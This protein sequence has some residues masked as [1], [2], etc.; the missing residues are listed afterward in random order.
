L[1]LAGNE[2]MQITYPTTPAQLF[3]L[4][5]RQVKQPAVK[6]LIV[7][8]PKGLLRHPACTSRVAD[9][10][11][12]GFSSIIE[13]PSEPKNVRRLILCSGRI[14]YDLEARRENQQRQDIAIIRLE[15]LYPL[16]T[17]GLKQVIG[18][19]GTFQDCLWV[20]EEPENMGAWPYIS[21]SL[22]GV[23]PVGIPFSYLGRE[24]SASPATGFYARHNQELANILNRAFEQ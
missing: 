3:H 13:D 5:R 22:P 7:L 8:T 21:F 1:A 20:Q 10:T 15:Q 12:G 14:Y 9:L 17:E 2:N 4:L 16:D 19:Y 18:K 24:R 6:P 11:D 23:L